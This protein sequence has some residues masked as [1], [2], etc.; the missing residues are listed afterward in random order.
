[1]PGPRDNLPTAWIH[2]DQIPK[3]PKGFLDDHEVDVF[4]EFLF[5]HIATR[6]VKLTL[7]ESAAVA[8]YIEWLALQGVRTTVA[9]EGPIERKYS[10]ARR[11]EKERRLRNNLDRLSRIIWGLLRQHGQFSASSREEASRFLKRHSATYFKNADVKSALSFLQAFEL[12]RDAPNPFKPSG[13]VSDHMSGPI[14]GTYFFDDLSERIYAAY[15][16]LKRAGVRWPGP[17][18][19]QALDRAAVVPT[20]RRQGAHSGWVPQDVNERVKEYDKRLRTKALRTR[21]GRAGEV[22]ASAWRDQLLDKWIYEFRRH[23]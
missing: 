6:P 23:V 22:L 20:R 12:P 11:T 4:L 9:S 5:A 17:R 21:K 3:A 2:S 7:R 14:D 16:G 15:H 13:L 10:G 1:M 18:V 19:A 8:R